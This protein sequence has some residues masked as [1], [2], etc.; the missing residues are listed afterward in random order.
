MH[1]VEQFVRELTVEINGQYPRPWMTEL[2]DPFTASVFVVGFNPASAYNSKDVDYERYI[3]SLFNRRGETCK[4]FYL[5]VTRQSSTRGNI[6]MF[7]NKLRLAG[8]TSVLETNVICYATKKSKHLTLPEHAG[9]RER[10]KTIFRSLVRKICPRVIVV[11]GKGVAKEFS[12]AFDLR[13]PLPSPPMSPAQ[14]VEYELEGNTTLLVIPSLALPGFNNWPKKPN[15][16]FCWW[17][18]EYLDKVA[19]RVALACAG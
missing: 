19:K 7:S 3:D 18:D 16:T 13:L 4:N 8:V 1:A 10:G 5:E 17:A 9:G 15:K 12:T 14:I 6:E 11:H 2:I